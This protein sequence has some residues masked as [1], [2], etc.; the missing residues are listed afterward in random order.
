MIC[1]AIAVAMQGE[2]LGA[3]PT[4]SQCASKAPFVNHRI[5]KPFP[6]K[7]NKNVSFISLTSLIGIKKVLMMYQRECILNCV[8]NQE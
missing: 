3:M 5:S 4:Q 8:S 2:E 1:L 6:F 7:I